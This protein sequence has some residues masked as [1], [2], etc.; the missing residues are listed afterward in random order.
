M[1]VPLIYMYNEFHFRKKKFLFAA[2]GIAKN[3]IEAMRRKQNY[4]FFW[5]YI[6]FFISH[7]ATSHF[8]QLFY[9]LLRSGE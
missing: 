6:I 5:L 4:I 2:G 3:F 8:L 7:I 1:H 9:P